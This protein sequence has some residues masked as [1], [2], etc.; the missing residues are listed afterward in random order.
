M[1]GT[2]SYQ[3]SVGP[4]YENGVEYSLLMHEGLDDGSYN[5]GKGSQAKNRGT[6]HRG[7]GVGMKFLTRSF[8]KVYRTA[9]MRVNDKMKKGMAAATR[10]KK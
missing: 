5:L 10:G 9:L 6:P 1:D 3:V 2:I 8:D 7:I 4:V